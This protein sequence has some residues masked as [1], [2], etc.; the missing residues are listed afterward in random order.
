MKL[1]KRT[2]YVSAGIAISA[3]LTGCTGMN[4]DFGCNAA[5]GDSCTP[6]S[7]VNEMANA[8]KYNGGQTVEG[9]IEGVSG[10][11]TFSYNDVG[12]NVTTP[13]PGEPIRYGESIQRI[14]IAP[15]EDA[16]GN[17]HDPSYIYTI[18]K[19]SH[20]IGVPANEIKDN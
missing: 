12:Y 5:A 2:I 18:I 4:S 10:V 17:Y 9:H 8:G 3:F 14:W 6:V 16:S 19:P 7:R 11:K 20:W 1:T 15:Y 13:K